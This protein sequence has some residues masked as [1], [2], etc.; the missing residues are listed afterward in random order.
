MKST[1]ITWAGPTLTVA[2]GVRQQRE[3]DPAIADT[4][5]SDYTTTAA[6]ADTYV[7]CARCSGR[8]CAK[9]PRVPTICCFC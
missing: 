1:N 6:Y 4:L 7:A 3:F 2:V 8:A 9:S 5:Y